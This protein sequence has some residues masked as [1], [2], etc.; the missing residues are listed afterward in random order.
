MIRVVRRSF[1]IG[2]LVALVST[3]VSCSN[4]G[5]NMNEGLKDMPIVEGEYGSEPL[6]TLPGKEP[7]A[8]LQTQDLVLGTGKEVLATSTLTVNYSLVTWSDERAVES[9]FSGEPATFALS[10]VIMGWQQGLLGVR[11]GGRR[12]LV[13]PPDL[14]YGDRQAGPIQPN[15]TLVFVV[16]VIGVS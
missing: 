7:P 3:V 13:I 16:D 14:G 9:S 10:G 8:T 5:G 4:E 2:M 15:E 12:L 11:E 1:F 6:I